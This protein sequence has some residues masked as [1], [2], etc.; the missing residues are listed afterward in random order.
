MISWLHAVRIRS[1][2]TS[3]TTHCSVMSPLTVIASS[4]EAEGGL[5]PNP[6]LQPVCHCIGVFSIT[7][8]LVYWLQRSSGGRRVGK[9]G[10]RN[11]LYIG[12]WNGRLRSRRRNW[13]WT[14]LGRRSFGIFNWTHFNGRSVELRRWTPCIRRRLWQTNSKDWRTLVVCTPTQPPRHLLS[15]DRQLSCPIFILLEAHPQ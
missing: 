13:K 6:I 4:Q 9:T 7:D 14:R 3:K 8:N 15:S 5:F 11:V 2:M 1:S 10:R 12:E